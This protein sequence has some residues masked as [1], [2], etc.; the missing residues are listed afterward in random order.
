MINTTATQIF[1]LI[2][3][4]FK[5]KGLFDTYKGPSLLG[6][7]RC[8]KKPSKITI[9]AYAKQFFTKILV[10]EVKKVEAVHQDNVIELPPIIVHRMSGYTLEMLK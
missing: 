6:G 4:K 2:M 1:L 7:D 9:I 10:I 5:I 8:G 3:D